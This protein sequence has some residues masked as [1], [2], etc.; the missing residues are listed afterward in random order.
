MS[1]QFNTDWFNLK[2]Y[3][4]YSNM[5]IEEWQWQ[6]SIR[7][8]LHEY[9]V[10]HYPSLGEIDQ[11]I[12]KSI[13]S[14]IIEKA[15]YPFLNN[16]GFLKPI[17]IHGLQPTVTSL[18][19]I[20]IWYLMQGL[21]STKMGKACE[22]YARFFFRNELDN[23]LAK[24][25]TRP[26][27]L[28]IKSYI[29]GKQLNAFYVSV[30]LEASDDQLKEDF[31]SWLKK[32]RIDTQK[33]KKRSYIKQTDFDQWVEYG[34]MPYLDLTFMSKL[35]G[36]KITQDKLGQL[37]FPDEFEV[38]IS[39]RIRKVTKPLAERLI[40]DDIGEF[41]KYQKFYKKKPE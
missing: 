40:N 16:I 21:T 39:E 30:D 38:T 4:S 9:Y 31:S 24:I 11:E 14:G 35:E 1:D 12:I 3:D 18:R 36:K 13:K 8:K 23:D 5:S 32:T 22:H 15:E 25:A 10:H 6:L 29:N 28:N 27:S 26:H 20:D 17:V 19:S 37:I 7:T 34:V 33:N 41:L 2:N